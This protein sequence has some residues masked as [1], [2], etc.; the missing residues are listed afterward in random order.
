MNVTLAQAAADIPWDKLSGLT[1]TAVLAFVV[2]LFLSNRICTTTTAQREIDASRREAE[3][4]KEI[5]RQQAERADKCEERM[6]ASAQI[7]R[8]SVEVAE[9]AVHKAGS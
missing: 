8:Q 5:A 3:V 7:A 9:K 2:W 6:L 1:G 4:W